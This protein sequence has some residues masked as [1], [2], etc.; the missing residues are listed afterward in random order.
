MGSY[1][2]REILSESKESFYRSEATATGVAPM[3]EH[4][5][6]K[7]QCEE[8]GYRFDFPETVKHTYAGPS[9]QSSSGA[10]APVAPIAP[11]VKNDPERFESQ[12]HTQAIESKEELFGWEWENSVLDSSDLFIFNSPDDVKAFKGLVQR[13]PD[14]S[15]VFLN[16]LM[17]RFMQNEVGDVGKAQS[18]AQM[19]SNQQHA[20]LDS[21]SLPKELKEV[22]TT[23]D[24]L[25][26]K[27]PD[28]YVATS[29]EQDL[30]YQVQS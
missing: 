18:V 7:S 24:D 5:S 1:P 19:N 23:Q 25:A 30:N 3:D 26:K 10:A 11:T 29:L 28:D 27:Y 16:S 17:S 13:S 2:Q 20:L 4:T 22:N 15:S 21:S 8:S 12:G 9:G 14:L 6:I